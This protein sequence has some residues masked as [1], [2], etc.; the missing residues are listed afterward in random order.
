MTNDQL[1]AVRRRLREG[2]Q[3]LFDLQGE[4]IAGLQEA[5]TA[6]S[7]SHDEM[8]ALMQTDNDLDDL[9]DTDGRP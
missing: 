1:R 6:L 2:H 5:L 8:V 3:R 7:R 4:Q 9:T